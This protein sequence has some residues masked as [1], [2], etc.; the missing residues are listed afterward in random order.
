MKVTLFM[1]TSINGYVTGQNDDTEWVKDTEILYTIIKEYGACVMGRRTYEESAKYNA[2][3]YKGA[4]NVVVT[5]DQQLISGS[6]EGATFTNSSPAELVK[7]LESKGY[8]K[9]LVVGGGNLNSQFLSAGLINEVIIDIHPLVIEK[10]VKLFEDVF[11][12]TSLELISS[13]TL[14]DGI[15][16]NHYKVTNK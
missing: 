4:L 9:L 10:G 1:A 2:F 7:L 8:E 16:Q 6:T 13:Q 3:P 14:T 5:H 12:R 11:P 15:V